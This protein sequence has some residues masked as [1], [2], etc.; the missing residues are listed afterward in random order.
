MKV[1]SQTNME[2]RGIAVSII[3]FGAINTINADSN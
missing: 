1:S 2:T 3:V